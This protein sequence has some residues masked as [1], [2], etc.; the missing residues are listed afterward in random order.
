MKGPA[1]AFDNALVQFNRAAKII[2]L[3][4]D[5]VAVI[6]E[7]RR[8][9]ECKLPVRMDDGSIHAFKGY[10]VQ[11]NIARGPAKGGVRFHPDVSLDEVKALAFWMTFKCATIGIPMGGGKGGVIVDPTK[12][13]HGELERL[14]RRYFA[15]MIELFG[16]DRDVPAPDVNTNPQ[17][18][19]WFMDTYSMHHGGDYLPAV[20]TGKP[21]EIG[22]SVGRNSATAQGMVFCVRRAA[23]HLGLSLSGATVAIQGYGNAG[24]YAAKLLREQGCK[25]VAVSDVAGA[26]TCKDGIDPNVAINH[27]DKH[28]N[29]KG[30]EK[31][32]GVEKLAD[33]MKLME[34]PVD[35]LIPAA[36]ENQITAKNAGRIKAK[37]I[38]E[39]ANGPCT[40]EADDILEKKRVFVIPDIL[41]NAGGV[42][43]SY[44]EWVQN[45]MGYYWRYE[46]VL[47]DLEHMMTTAFD[48][49]LK[50][51]L[52]HDVPMRTAAFI[53]SIG[54]VAKASELRGL[55]A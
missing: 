33:P 6:R 45:R 15:E 26:F 47:E 30:F 44:L 36:L 43:V 51:S 35:I 12:L 23:A 5:Q 32:R 54:R 29:L 25:I 41:C 20:V 48:T 39:C 31:V 24:S 53:V 18:M 27:V 50:V 28:K 34:L 7:P 22:G 42:G 3:T 1:S 49:V 17:V 13:S 11:H 10:R 46:R 38:A 40:P 16:P 9:V 55:Y 4:A 2:K 52:E 21:L 8:I 14:S 19:A 37:I